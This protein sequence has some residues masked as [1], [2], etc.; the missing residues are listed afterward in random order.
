M[1]AGFPAGLDEENL[2]LLRAARQGD[3]EAFGSLY[4][5]FAPPVFRYLYAHLDE[6]LDAEDLTAEV[7]LRVWQALPGFRET[8][9]PF[10]GFLFRVA[11]NALYDHFRRLLSAPL[12]AA[13]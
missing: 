12:S 4:E 3:A 11:R 1:P 2:R 9:A 10:L 5:R 7:F 8:E 6:R 13:G